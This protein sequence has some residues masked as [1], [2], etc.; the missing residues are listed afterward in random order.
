MRGLNRNQLKYIAII[1]ML[2]D[3]IGMHFVSIH[4]LP[5][6]LCRVLGRLAAPIMF[7]FLA[8][9]F[10]YTRSK[11]KYAFRLGGFALISQIPYA[12]ANHDTLLTVDLNVIYTMF[13]SF[14]LLLVLEKM[15]EG[16]WRWLAAGGLIG[17]SVLGDWG[18]FGPLYVMAFYFNHGNRKAEVKNYC[19]ISAGMVILQIAFC[20]ANDY[21]WYGELW[22]LG[23]FLF[24][25][26]LYLYNGEPGSRK[27]FHKWFFYI[28]YPVHLLVIWIIQYKL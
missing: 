24:I 17:A 20:I 22:Q 9:G 10:R 23:L 25:P 14:L 27:Q 13:L 6:I 8:E 4:T 18:I 11:K 19:T 15:P 7:L 12:L 1:S 2:I 5:G 28:F 21:H 26:V 3:H 16:N